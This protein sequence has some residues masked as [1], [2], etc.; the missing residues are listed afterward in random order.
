MSCKKG[1]KLGSKVMLRP[2]K[3]GKKFNI[4]DGKQIKKI[5]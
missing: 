2:W 5:I 3:K 4:K 1:L